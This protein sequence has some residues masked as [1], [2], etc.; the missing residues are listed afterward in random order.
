MDNAFMEKK[1]SI[2]L[3][4]DFEVNISA[5]KITDNNPPRPKPFLCE[6]TA[7]TKRFLISTNQVGPPCQNA[8]WVYQD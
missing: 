4:Y 6:T 5:A 3:I 8:V 7:R 2:P 1:E